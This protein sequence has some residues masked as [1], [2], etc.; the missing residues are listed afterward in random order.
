MSV[1]IIGDLYVGLYATCTSIQ[2]TRIHDLDCVHD[3]HIRCTCRYEF[4]CGKKR[5]TRI[6]DAYYSL[7]RV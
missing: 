2:K 1:K 5:H 4:S 3:V 7:A 6:I